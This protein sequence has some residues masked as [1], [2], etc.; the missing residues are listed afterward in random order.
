LQEKKKPRTIGILG[1]SFVIEILEAVREKPKRFVDLRGHCANEKTRTHRLKTLR[2]NG[3]IKT[4]ILEI[5][6]QSFIHYTLTN[7]GEKALQLLQQ[8][9]TMITP[10]HQTP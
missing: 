8:L 6:G 4:I 9:E 3:F 1:K 2:R 10:K 7:K 5:K